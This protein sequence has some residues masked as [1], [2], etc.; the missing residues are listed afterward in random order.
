MAFF[1]WRLGGLA[2]A[3]ALLLWV[4]VIA[5][6]IVFRRTG[7]IA[8]LLLVPYLAWVGYACA[9]NSYLWKL[10]PSVLG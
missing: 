9:L 8:P 4:L 7:T 1:A 6:I 5:M 10:N 2:L 3:D